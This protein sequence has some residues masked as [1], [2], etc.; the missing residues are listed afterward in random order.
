MGIRNESAAVTLLNTVA[1][2]VSSESIEAIN[3]FKSFTIEISAAANVHI[4]AT[5]DPRVRSDPT[6]AVW[7]QLGATITVTGTVVL[8]N[9]FVHHRARVDTNT[10]TVVVRIGI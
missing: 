6:N 5:N 2:A 1:A 8:E 4:E 10:G 3:L 9:S 7:F